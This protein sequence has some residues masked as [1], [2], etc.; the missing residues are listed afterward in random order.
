M[1]KKVKLAIVGCGSTFSAMYGPVLKYLDNGEIVAIADNNKK[2]LKY[3]QHLYNIYNTYNDFQSMLNNE[4]FEGIIIGTPPA[5]HYEL[6]LEA[7]KNKKHIL[8]EKP[9]A[10]TSDECSKMIDT[11]KKEKVA[12]MV[13][14]MKRFNKC[15]KMAKELMDDG[16]LGKILSINT[17]WHVPTGLKPR[18]DKTWKDSLITLGGIFQD[19]GSHAVNL[20]LW[21]LGEVMEVSGQVRILCQKELEDYVIATCVHRN[22]IISSYRLL[23]VSHKPPFEMYEIYGSKGTLKIIMK[24]RESYIS[25]E[26]FEMLLYKNGSILKNI[27]PKNNK[28]LDEE[29][30]TSNQYLLQLEHFCKTIL[31]NDSSTESAEEGKKVVEIVNGVYLSSSRK[32]NVSLP[33]RDSL[34]LEKIFKNIKE[35]AI[36]EHDY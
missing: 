23:G 25:T 13:G 21:W 8:C 10:R 28:N 5:T 12:L 33:L 30:K 35:D 26:P 4:E 34:N 19:M 9:L 22:R 2:K 32:Q 16:V 27:T 36:M 17:E 14:Y 3:A 7:A 18:K 20:C 24:G 29:I 1:G 11:C 6:V 15:F 31:R